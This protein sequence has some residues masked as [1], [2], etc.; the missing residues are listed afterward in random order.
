MDNIPYK[1]FMGIF[2]R[3]KVRINHKGAYSAWD[4]NMRILAAYYARK[5]SLKKVK[6]RKRFDG[7]KK[8][9]TNLRTLLLNGYS[10][11]VIDEAQAD[12][13]G[14]IALTLIHGVEGA[15]ETKLSRFRKRRGK[16][17]II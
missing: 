5:D 4:L 13:N 1:K 17:R 16:M 7:I 12:P 2:D 6:T 8:N 3:T 10:R 14:I 11:R 15:K 9:M